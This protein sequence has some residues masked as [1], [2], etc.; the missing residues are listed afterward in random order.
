M[1][2]VVRLVLENT[3]L[4]FRG[5]FSQLEITVF[6]LSEAMLF[7]GCY[8][9]IIKN[10]QACG[11]LS[12]VLCVLVSLPN[13]LSNLTGWQPNQSLKQVRTSTQHLPSPVSSQ[14]HFTSTC[15][16]LKPLHFTVETHWNI[17]S[18]FH[19]PWLALSLGYPVFAVIY[20]IGWVTSLR[21]LFWWVTNVANMLRD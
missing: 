21:W 18:W 4:V 6:P 16:S 13:G 2:P 8:G 14:I 17:F 5:V 12:A 11:W 15:F 1:C 3:L 9:K 19:G 20:K 10:K 7:S